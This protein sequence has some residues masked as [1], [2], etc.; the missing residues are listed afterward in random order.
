[1]VSYLKSEKYQ[2]YPISRDAQPSTIITEMAVVIIVAI[3]A[4]MTP[5]IIVADLNSKVNTF[6]LYRIQVWQPQLSSSVLNTLR[7]PEQ[8][9]V[10]FF[11]AQGATPASLL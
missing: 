2:Y 10:D 5:A 1:V 11:K 8:L 7:T 9:P 6:I 4:T 3:I